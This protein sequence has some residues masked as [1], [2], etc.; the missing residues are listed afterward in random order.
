[1]TGNKTFKKL[2]TAYETHMVKIPQ[3]DWLARKKTLEKALKAYKS[4][5]AEDQ[6]DASLVEN[7]E[8]TLTLARLTLAEGLLMDALAGDGDGIADAMD[9]M[10]ADGIDE[11]QVHPEIWR[12]AQ[13]QLS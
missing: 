8:N 7:A 10:A 11:T 3:K 12:R 6:Q 9:G 1:M 2:Q 5:C 4:A 13:L